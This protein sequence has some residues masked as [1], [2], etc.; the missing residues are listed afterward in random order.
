MRF[1]EALVAGTDRHVGE[2]IFNFR[3]DPALKAAFTGAA[4]A[5]YRPA[6]EV[7]RRF[8][9]CD[10]EQKR[11]SAFDAEVLRQSLAVA[12]RAHYPKSDEHDAMRELAAEHS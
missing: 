11:R 2:T 7:L 4:E 1:Q 10:V 12:A 9:R 5:D 3:F 8:M 6:A